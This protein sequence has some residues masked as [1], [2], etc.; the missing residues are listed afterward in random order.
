VH[1]LC[2]IKNYTFVVCRIGINYCQCFS[3]GVSR[4]IDFRFHFW[5]WK[6]VFLSTGPFT[7]LATNTPGGIIQ[8]GILLGGVPWGYRA[9]SIFRSQQKA[10]TCRHSSELQKFSSCCFHAIVLYDI[11]FNGLIVQ[12]V[13]RACHILVIISFGMTVLTAAWCIHFYVTR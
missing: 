6:T 1:A 8:H 13:I 3:R 2:F 5:Y 12:L 11:G 10:C 7:G 9:K 4:C